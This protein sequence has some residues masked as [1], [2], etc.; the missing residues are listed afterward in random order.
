V[1]ERY[2]DFL[3]A[4]LSGVLSEGL[5]ERLMRVVILYGALMLLWDKALSAE[6]GSGDESREWD[7]WIGHLQ[8]LG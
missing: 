6:T 1:V 4:E 8:V 3:Q 7:W 2:H 5:W